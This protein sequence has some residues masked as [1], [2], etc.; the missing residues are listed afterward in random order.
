[1]VFPLAYEETPLVY[2]VPTWTE[3]DCEEATDSCAGHGSCS[4]EGECVCDSGWYGLVNE[5]SC[6]T[7]CAGDL[8]SGVC[9]SNAVFYIGGIDAGTLASSQELYAHMR[10]AVELVNNKTDGWF[11]DVRQV[12]LVLNTSD[13]FCSYDGGVSAVKE[14]SAWASDAKGLATGSTSLD[15]VIGA[16]CSASR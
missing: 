6:D 7:Y 2:P 4:D 1:M 13:G 11:D 3:R 12:S 5:D 15:G 14:L 16:E 8:A 10:L 9:R